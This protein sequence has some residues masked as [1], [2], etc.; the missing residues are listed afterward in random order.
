MQFF[1]AQNS[2]PSG[3][4]QKIGKNVAAILVERA[5][6]ERKGIGRHKLLT[7]AKFWCVNISCTGGVSR[8]G[9][10]RT[11]ECGARKEGLVML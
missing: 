4:A 2:G 9:D 5:S 6:L 1:I 8:S 11:S 10:L 7:Q 3:L